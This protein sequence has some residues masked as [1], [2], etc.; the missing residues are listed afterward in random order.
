MGKGDT[1]YIDN[2]KLQQLETILKAAKIDKDMIAQ[3]AKNKKMADP[4]LDFLMGKMDEIGLMPKNM[5]KYTDVDKDIMD[6]EMMIKNYTQK[7]LKR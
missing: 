1:D 4:G 7:K 6:V 3:I 2:L 5:S